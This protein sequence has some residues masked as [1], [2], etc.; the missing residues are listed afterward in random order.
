[1]MNTASLFLST[2][3]SSLL[4]SQEPPADAPGLSDPVPVSQRETD[5]QPA[6][7]AAD[8]PVTLAD[9]EALRAATGEQRAADIA[10]ADA[11]FAALDTLQARF[12]QFAPNG[13]ESNG[14]LALD[15]PGRVR[16]DYDDPSPILLVADGSTVALA[17]FDLETIDRVPLSATPLRHVLG[18][19]PLNASEAVSDVNRADGRIYITLVDP[20]GE[21]D[22]RLTLIFHD[23]KPDEAA[24]TMTLEGWYVVDAMGGLTEL[25][26]SDV[27]RNEDLNPRLFILDDE[28]VMGDDRRRGRR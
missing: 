9:A 14:D 3:L 2:V 24:T 25:R 27:T 18:S 20:E 28:D 1:M 21:T 10:R 13:T 17:D 5:A 11:W 26:L 12:V 23:A 22:G 4:A 19:E 15:R 6:E 7:P 8:A 16:F